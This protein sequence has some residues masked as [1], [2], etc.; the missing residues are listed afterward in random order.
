[1]RLATDKKASSPPN[2]SKHITLNIFPCKQ[3]HHCFFRIVL[4]AANVFFS[5]KNY[6]KTLLSSFYS[7]QNKKKLKSKNFFIRVR[8]KRIS[9]LNP[10]LI[11][12]QF[13]TPYITQTLFVI[14][15]LFHV[16]IFLLFLKPFEPF[17]SR[18]IIQA[19]HLYCAPF[20]V[21]KSLRRRL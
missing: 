8:Q 16:I 19:I 13:S 5:L 17:F 18:W 10:P 2:N 1:M 6:F 14:V 9:R 15:P 21:F 7:V 11:H 3:K 12:P 4:S 20:S